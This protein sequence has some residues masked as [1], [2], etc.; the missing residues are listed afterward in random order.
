MNSAPC[1]RLGWA[2]VEPVVAQFAG[3][4]AG[5]A[6]WAACGGGVSQRLVVQ[7]TGD[8]VCVAFESAFDAAVDV[9]RALGLPVRMVIASGEAE[10][11]GGDYDGMADL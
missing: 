1:K 7:H 4:Q 11:R 8:G 2:G 10:L 3:P 5:S 9:Q 6:G